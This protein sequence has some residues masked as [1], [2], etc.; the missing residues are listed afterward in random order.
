MQHLLTIAL[1][2]LALALPQ[3]AASQERFPA[4]SPEQLTPEQ[5]AYADS[6]SKPPRNANYKNPPYAVFIRNP[7]LA[8]KVEA[9]SDYVRWNTGQ[10][11]RLTE[12]AIMITA[13]HWS[14]HWI[15]R[16][17]YRAA[18]RGG[19]DP[20]VGAD[21]AAGKR[22]SAMK[23]DE[24]IL[25]D[26]ATEMYRTKAVSDATYA[27][28]VKAFGERGLIDLVATMGYYDM[29][30]MTLITAKAIPPREDDV[31][32]LLALTP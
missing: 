10:P 11:A 23:E 8:R 5:K 32:Q 15:W 14:S 21:I 6:I 28:A 7:E 1:T 9:I 12:L 30:A 29:V 2:A 19:L 25:Y 24:T 16:S 20:S 13:R 3:R 17:H 4:L 26:Y 31:P 27:I 18:V 22:P